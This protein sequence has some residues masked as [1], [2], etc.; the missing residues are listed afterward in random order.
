MSITFHILRNP[1]F[2]STKAVFSSNQFSADFYSNEKYSLST[3]WVIWK[4]LSFS[5]KSK[6]M[7]A[8]LHDT[9]WIISSI[10]K[11]THFVCNCFWWNDE[12]NK[13]QFHLIINWYLFYNK[14]PRKGTVTHKSLAQIFFSKNIHQNDFKLQFL[15]Y[16]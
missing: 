3:F 11:F 14:K 5:K 1:I 12:N 10:D 4:P 8:L 15:I 16:N 9:N 6:Y 13:L 7:I 2:T